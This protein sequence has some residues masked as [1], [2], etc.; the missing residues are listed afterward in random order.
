MKVLK[1]QK[2]I[3]LPEVSAE[4]LRANEREEFPL[5]TSSGTRRAGFPHRSPLGNRPHIQSQQL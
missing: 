4:R 3:R 1:R 5:S 2:G